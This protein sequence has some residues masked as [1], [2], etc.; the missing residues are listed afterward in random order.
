MLMASSL[1]NPDSGSAT[2]CGYDVMKE[3]DGVRRSI[4]FVFEEE[5]VDIYLTGKQNLDFAARMLQS[6]KRRAGTESGCSLKDRWT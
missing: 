5:A 6:L 3:K 4:G 2:V 1:L